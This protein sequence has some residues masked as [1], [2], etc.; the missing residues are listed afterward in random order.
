LTKKRSWQNVLERLTFDS[1]AIL[2]FY[3]GEEGGRLL[4]TPSKKS[5]TEKLK[6]TLT[7]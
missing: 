5:R 4:G 6:A 3:L 2:A 7:Y 1:E